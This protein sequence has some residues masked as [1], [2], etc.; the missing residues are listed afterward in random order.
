MKDSAGLPHPFREWTRLEG[1]AQR[2]RCRRGEVLYSPGDA[3]DSVF[4]IKSGKVKIGRQGGN[5]KAVILHLVGSGEFFGEM[6]L[7]GETHRENT[8]QVIEEAAVWVVPRKILTEWLRPRPE[9][10]QSIWT[11]VYRRLR[12]LENTVERFLFWDVEQRLI[13]LLLDLANQYGE[14]SPDGLSLKIELSQKEVAQLVGATRETTSTAL[15]RLG[16]RGL[17]RIR[18]R[19]LTLTSL[20]ELTSLM[21]PLLPPRI[22]PRKAK[23]LRARARTAGSQ[24]A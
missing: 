16:K 1:V 11:V 6:S 18:R 15:N 10:W 13:R 7:L 12:S 21:Q 5:G 8:A 17:I 3:S 19:R 2:L 14:P 24:G 23:P 22:P 20:A 9:A 4:V